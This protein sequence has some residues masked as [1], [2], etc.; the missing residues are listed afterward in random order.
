MDS[1][2]GVLGGLFY[3]DAP[4]MKIFVDDCDIN[5]STTSNDGKGGI[6][7]ILEADSFSMGYS[8]ISHI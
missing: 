5:N 2:K 6:A 7:Y 1:T 3:I 4:G 8:K